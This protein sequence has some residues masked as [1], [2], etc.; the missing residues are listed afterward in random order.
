MEELLEKEK[1]KVEKET[2]V[3]FEKIFWDPAI[4]LSI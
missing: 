3:D 2:V 4:E 1:I